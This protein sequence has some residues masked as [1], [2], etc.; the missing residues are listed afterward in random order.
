MKIIVNKCFGGFSLSK[1]VYDELS[2]PWDNYG[3]LGNKDFGIESDNYYAYHSDPRLV[4][5]VEKLGEKASSGSLAELR[6]IN[7]PDGIQ[8]E[9][10]EYDGIETVHEVHRSW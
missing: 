4:T 8:W 1:A 5:A 6:V 9:I 3:Y 10:D 2:I 7:I